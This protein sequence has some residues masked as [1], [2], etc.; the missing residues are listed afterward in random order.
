[1]E[2]YQLSYDYLAHSRELTSVSA[3]K[4]KPVRHRRRR[5]QQQQQQQHHKACDATR[6]EL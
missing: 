2:D 5:R 6:V 1:M 4:Q 3:I